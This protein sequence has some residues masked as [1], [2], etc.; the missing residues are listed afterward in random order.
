M[1]TQ[2][3]YVRA[4][5]VLATWVDSANQTTSAQFPM[6]ARGQTAE[7]IIGFFANADAEAIMT[8]EEVQQYVAWDFGY[9][10][11]YNTQSTPKIRTTTGFAVDANGFLHIPIDTTSVELKSAIGNNETITLSAELDGYLAGEP[12]NPALI[13][14]WNGQSFRNRIIEGGTGTPEPVDDGV[15]TKAQT[16]ALVGGEIVYQFSADGET[17]HDTQTEADVYIRSKNGALATGAWS[18]AMKLPSGVAG[19]DGESSYVHVAYAS[20]NQ[21]T[22]ISLTPSSALKYRAE[23]V[24]TSPTATT[25]DFS[26]ATWVKYIGDDGAGSGDMTKAVYDTNDNGKVDIAEVAETANAVSWTGVTGKPESF[27]PASHTHSITD[28]G[29]SAVLPVQ[30]LNYSPN[31]LRI[32]RPLVRIN[33]D[34]TSSITVDIRSIVDKDGN[35]VTVESDKCYTW[36]YHVL[37]NETITMVNVGSAQ[38]T[39]YPVNIPDVLPLVLGTLTW[40]VFAIRGFY[41][42]GAEGN[43]A[44]AVNYAY[45]YPY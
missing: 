19:Q 41:K 26:G 43:I 4:D 8:Q 21:G 30:T 40:H 29:D 10:T 34:K 38:S 23:I 5:S 44:Y 27:T 3:V 2:T 32:D 25:A 39:M 35:P 11:D 31:T 22:G 24:N 15:Y 18:A 37:C 17:W 16:N 20:D 42:A 13:V 33:G 14:Q 9:D 6:L 36:E 12:D 7:L 1:Q 28:I 45:S